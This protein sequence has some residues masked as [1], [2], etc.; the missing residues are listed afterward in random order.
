MPGRKK[1]LEAFK[2]SGASRVISGHVHCM[3]DSVFE[4]IRF[5]IA[6]D[7]CG[8]QFTDVWQEGE[9]KQGFYVHH[10]EGKNMKREFVPLAKISTREDEYGPGG[11]PK[12]EF[13]DYSIAWEK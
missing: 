3:R 4:G 13:R 7:V 5:E 2:S 8:T 11:H 10:V 6:P 1:L 9:G 12:P